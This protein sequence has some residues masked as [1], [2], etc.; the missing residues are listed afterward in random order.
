VA[1]APTPDHLADLGYALLATGRLDE[2]TQYIKQARGLAPT[3]A[4]AWYYWCLA[5]A[6]VECHGESNRE[7]EALIAAHPE[8]APAKAELALRWEQRGN[9][10]QALLE[11]ESVLDS[12][13]DFIPARVNI[14]R[15][16]CKRGQFLDAKPQ[17]HWLTTHGVPVE[18]VTRGDELHVVINGAPIFDGHLSGA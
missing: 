5:L 10:Q 16:L 12:S 18:V 13:P 6:E 15:L 2:A 7:L 17:L 11:L 1:H 8:H 3:H 4:D 14:V 9:H